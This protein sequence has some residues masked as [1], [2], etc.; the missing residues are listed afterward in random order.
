M[1]PRHV[2]ATGATLPIPLAEAGSKT[3]NWQEAQIALLHVEQSPHRK[4]LRLMASMCITL[5]IVDQKPGDGGAAGD[6]LDT[7]DLIFFEVIGRFTPDAITTVRQI[8]AGSRVPIIVFTDALRPECT[9]KA[10][11][12]GAD[13]VLLD[14]M[15]PDTL[16]QAV[17]ITAG[18]AVT[19]ASGNITPDTA[20]AIAA[21][22]VDLLAVGWI[23]H[24]APTLDI[25]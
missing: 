15:T 25:G 2:Y 5:K 16:R 14:N 11:E 19:E 8:R 3:P 7:S 13:V 23:T 12:A 4:T 20:A 1:N 9:A 24:S 22:G 6:A 18:R 17:A 21:S 10:L